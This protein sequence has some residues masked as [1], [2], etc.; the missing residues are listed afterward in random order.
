MVKRNHS[1]ADPALS[2]K[3]FLIQISRKVLF[4]SLMINLPVNVIRGKFEHFV[5]NVFYEEAK[6]KMVVQKVILIKQTT[7]YILMKGS[8]LF[9]A[10]LTFIIMQR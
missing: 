9:S 8:F 3:S 10:L 1:E 5:T 6:C 4:R 2:V 7:I